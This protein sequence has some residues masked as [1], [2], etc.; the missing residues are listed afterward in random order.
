MAFSRED[1]AAAMQEIGQC[2]DDVTRRSLLVALGDNLKSVFDENET[3]SQANQTFENEN[4]RLQ[5]VNMQLFL[6]VGDQ[7]AGT[8]PE[9]DPEPQK[10]SF[11]D[12]FNEKGDIK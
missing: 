7:A 10:K 1:Y 3:L 5:D 2:E 9:P 12:L 4:K 8:D 11:T 6:R